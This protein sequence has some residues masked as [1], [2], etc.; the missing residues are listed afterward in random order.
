M[1]IR[2]YIQY[3]NCSSIELSMYYLIC[4]MVRCDDAVLIGVVWFGSQVT[5]DKS[6]LTRT[7]TLAGDV[8]DPSGT[9]TGGELVCLGWVCVHVVSVK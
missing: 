4:C 9:L 8:F 6:V 2:T 7:V 1:N 3:R 5:F